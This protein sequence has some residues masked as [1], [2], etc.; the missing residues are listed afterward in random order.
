MFRA[1]SIYLEGSS[2]QADGAF[3]LP[4]WPGEDLAAQPPITPSSAAMAPSR[5]P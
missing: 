2:A 5:L 1:K 4:A 3:Q